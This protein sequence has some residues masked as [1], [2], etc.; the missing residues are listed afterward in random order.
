MRAVILLLLLSACA[1]T[2][3]LPGE[4]DTQEYIFSQADGRSFNLVL[5]ADWEPHVEGGFLK[6]NDRNR[7]LAMDVIMIRPR[8]PFDVTGLQW[9][10]LAR[11]LT[12]TSLSAQYDLWVQAGRQE[13]L[14]TNRSLDLIKMAPQTWLR[15]N[16]FRLLLER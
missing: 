13:L 11:R 10:R 2:A 16:D 14:G 3:P 1:G 6:I 8:V 9:V 4:V 5:P 15:P 7:V 12:S